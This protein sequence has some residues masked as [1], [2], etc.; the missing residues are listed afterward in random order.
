MFSS[1]ISNQYQWFKN[2]DAIAGETNRTYSYQGAEG[3]FNVVLYEDKCNRQSDPVLISGLN[4]EVTALGV[5]PVPASD[6][7][8]FIAKNIE[9]ILLRD[10]LGRQH[11]VD[12]S[13]NEQWV[14]VSSLPNGV[15]LLSLGTGAGKAVS[16]RI[17]VLR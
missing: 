8:Y 4:N 12:W 11:N 16:M 6:K 14:D 13:S 3:L 1:A 2:D 10:H 15:Y 5:F 9:G 17:V 7:I